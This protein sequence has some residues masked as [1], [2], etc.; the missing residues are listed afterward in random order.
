MSSLNWLDWT[1]CIG[2]LVIVLAMGSWFA[3]TQHTN[4]DYFVGGRRMH[5]LPI[6]LSLFASVFSS[7]SFAALSLFAFSSFCW[8]PVIVVTSVEDSA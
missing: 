2:Y 5:W 8:S 1:I 6:G 4:E 7:L 3:R